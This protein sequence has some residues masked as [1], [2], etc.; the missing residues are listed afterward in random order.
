MDFGQDAP[1]H[2]LLQANILR[3]FAV[4]KVYADRIGGTLLCEYRADAEALNQWQLHQIE[5]DTLLTGV[6]DVYFE[7]TGIN[8][9]KLA[10]LDT[11]CFGSGTSDGIS[12]PSSDVRKPAIK[13]SGN[14][15]QMETTSPS[16]LFIY[17]MTGKLVSK[18]TFNAGANVQSLSH[19]PAGTYFATL[20]VE[21]KR[22]VQK[23]TVK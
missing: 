11:F 8:K 19:L 5:L 1:T 7:L 20:L 14:C 2:L 3:A 6:H 21:G 23:F 17:N 15:L 12:S 18:K 10:Y 16:T 4:I 9:V 13:F 22:Y